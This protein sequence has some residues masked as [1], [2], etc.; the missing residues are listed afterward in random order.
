MEAAYILALTTGLFGGF[1]HCLG[2]CGPLVA[3]YSLHSRESS[4]RDHLT[5]H[6][7]YN[8]GRITTYAFIGAVLGLT[9]T[10]VNIAGR[11]AGIQ[12]LVAIIAGLLMIAAG[13]RISG[14]IRA[15]AFIDSHNSLVIRAVRTVLEGESVWRFYP[16]GLLLGFM[17]C[18]LSYSVFLGAAGSG[19]T[20]Q[21]MF[22]LTCFGLGTIPALMLFGSAMTYVGARVRETI[23]K[24]GGV[25]VTLM[26]VYFL[27]RGLSLYA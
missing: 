13:L 25:A 14:L 19:G 10:F 11:V 17:P 7:I 23:Y 16:M 2:M 24:A 15:M 4:I 6:L 5:P 3:S 21:G 27:I 18:G 8:A 22:L 12:N 9:G 20:L 1:G 26:G